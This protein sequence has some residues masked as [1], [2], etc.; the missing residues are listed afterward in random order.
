M[1][2]RLSPHLDRVIKA[3]DHP[4]SSKINKQQLP[5]SVRKDDVMDLSSQ[6]WSAV[7]SMDHVVQ[8]DTIQ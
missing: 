5:P 4:D 2:K 1:A 8:Y 3:I 6:L 7:D